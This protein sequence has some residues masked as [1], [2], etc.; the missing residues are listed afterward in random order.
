[1]ASTIAATFGEPKKNSMWI[2]NPTWDLTF[3]SLSSILVALPFTVYIIPQ[4]FGIDAEVSRNIVNGT[5]AFLIGGPHM[6]S[7]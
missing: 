3:I 1:M 7:T 6:Y 5:I 2:Y 4:L